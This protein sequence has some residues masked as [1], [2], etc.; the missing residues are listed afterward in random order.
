M[1]KHIIWIVVLISLAYANALMGDFV[2]DDYAG[3]VYN[4]FIKSA[5]NIPLLF[6]RRYLTHPL[7]A[8][9]NVGAYNIG[10][11]EGSYRPVATL[12]YF[13]NYAVFKL[14][15]FGWRLANLLI[16]ILCAL[17]IYWLMSIIF[18]KPQLSYFCAV[19]FGLHPV[20]AEVVNCTIFRSNS[21]ALLFCLLALMLYFK[22]RRSQAESKYLYLGASLI[23]SFLA[24]F[25]KEIAVILPLAII[26]CEYYQSG[27][28][29]SALLRN[30]RFYLL[31]FLVDVIYLFVYFVMMPPTQ[32]IFNAPAIL[33]NLIRMFSVTGVYLKAMLF[34]MDLALID[35]LEIS[36]SGLFSPALGM[37]AFVL[38]SY[39]ILKIKKLPPE[40]SFGVI[41]FLLWLLPM[42]NF[43]NSFRIMAAYRYLYLAMP[44]CAV[45]V[46]FILSKIR[47]ARLDMPV[48]QRLVPF[49]CFGY[50]VIF[51]VSA[52]AIWK[53]DMILNMTMVEK[54]PESVDAHINFGTALLKSGDIA[55]AKEE[56]SFILHRPEWAKERIL[57]ASTAYS[58]LGLIHMEEGEY[59]RAE[60]MYRKA[61]E[62][63]PHVAYIYTRLGSCYAKQGLYE[64]ALGY[65]NQAK[66][67]NP[68][69]APAYLATGIIYSLMHKY[70]Q[71]KS[72][73]AQALKINP[74]YTEAR[75]NLKK[76]LG[77]E[78]GI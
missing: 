51:T 66:T 52:N 53:N 8:A 65:F 31:Y 61:L 14:D 34:P 78:Q 57:E 67:M 38:S 45:L 23:F 26:L 76:I 39:V 11:G 49:A 72:E 22:F 6:S 56:L 40:I 1:R 30:A 48:L 2:Y 55:A 3:I 10:S 77:L 29:S 44:G 70:G 63:T 5:K 15:P 19:I 28:N 69:Y 9:F 43:I 33:A 58:N 42:N 46:A 71:A 35:P 54:N 27:F 41:W 13:I 47:Q 32:G 75:D 21:L 4:G 60:E 74:D 37:S 24:V 50:F 20:N 12:S 36:R 25:S 18:A 68:R 17:L 64:K 7:E 73:F 62:L 16:H 59:A